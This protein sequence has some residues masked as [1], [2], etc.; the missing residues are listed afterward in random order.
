MK[1]ALEIALE[2]TAKLSEGEATVKLTDDQRAKIAE[3]EQEYRAKIAE[4]EIMAE[5]H[6]KALALQTSG[7]E[8]S[9]QVMLLRE[10]LNQDKQRLDAEKTARVQAVRDGN[11]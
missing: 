2:R 1:S 4:Q 6:I 7:R 10:Q 5:T 3:L 11:A 9:E 8:F